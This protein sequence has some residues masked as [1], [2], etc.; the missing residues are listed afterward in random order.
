[1]EGSPFRYCTDLFNVHEAYETF[2]S[3]LEGQENVSGDDKEKMLTELKHE[4]NVKVTSPNL[5]CH[6]R[7]R[8]STR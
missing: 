2:K 5:S 1:M 3:F 8:T 4:L 6:A 7:L